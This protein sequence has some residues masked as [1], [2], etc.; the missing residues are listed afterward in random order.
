MQSSGKSATAEPRSEARFARER[1]S[2]RL[3]GGS[4][5]RTRGMQTAVRIKPC[6]YNEAKSLFCLASIIH[7]A[8]TAETA[9]RRVNFMYGLERVGA[10]GE[11]GGGAI[12]L[13]A[14]MKSAIA[15]CERQIGRAHV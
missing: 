6:E 1:I 5:T 11:L 7:A 15:R 3:K 2:P 8:N 12:G 14:G 4:A 9:S 10:S 13:L